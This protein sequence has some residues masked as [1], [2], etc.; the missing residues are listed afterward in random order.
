M[1]PFT[2]VLRGPVVLSD[3][4]V[5]NDEKKKEALQNSQKIANGPCS[6]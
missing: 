6:D 4:L 5:S 2:S 3:A 1:Q